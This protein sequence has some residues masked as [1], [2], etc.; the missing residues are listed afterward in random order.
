MVV[1]TTIEHNGR[2]EPSPKSRQDVE[3]GRNAVVAS[4]ARAVPLPIDRR[5]G[6][7]HHSCD[8]IAALPVTT[9]K[10]FRPNYSQLETVAMRRRYK[11][12]LRRP[13]WNAGI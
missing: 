4:A 12:C 8:S 10:K 7:S 5:C 3:L 1:T 13:D 2:F 6:Q 9:W 11:R